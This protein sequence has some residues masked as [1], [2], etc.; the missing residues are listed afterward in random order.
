MIYLYYIYS[1]IAAHI[2]YKIHFGFLDLYVVH[3]AF[4][5]NHFPN[6]FLY[7]RSF[8]INE[9]RMDELDRSCMIRFML[10]PKITSTGRVLRSRRGRDMKFTHGVP[11][12][13][14][15]IVLDS[16]WKNTLY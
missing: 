15:S 7:Y 13:I 5:L 3:I 16:F 1:I 9:V 14:I 6:F 11:I 12:S 2:H 4:L 10:E 8:V